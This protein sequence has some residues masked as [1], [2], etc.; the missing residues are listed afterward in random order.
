MAYFFK[1]LDLPQGKEKKMNEGGQTLQ[2]DFDFSEQ[3]AAVAE[4]A[5]ALI[6]SF[7]LTVWSI[8]TIV[9]WMKSTTTTRHLRNCATMTRLLISQ[10]FESS[11]GVCVLASKALWHCL[12]KKRDMK[13]EA[14]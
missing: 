13:V 10:T 8:Q 12:T 9:Y 2:R 14:T 1:I 6:S 11:V 5:G 4:I 3:R 7:K